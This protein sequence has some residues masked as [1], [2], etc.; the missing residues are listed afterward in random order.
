MHATQILILKTIIMKN[1]LLLAFFFFSSLWF[2]YGQTTIA[3]QNFDGETSWNFASNPSP[4]NISSDVWNS[5]SSIGSINSGNSENFWGMRDLDNPNGG[6]NFDH[7]LTFNA[8]DVSNYNDVV[9]SFD[10]YTVGYESSDVIGYEIWEDNIKTVEVYNLNKSTSAWVNVTYNVTNSANSV[11]LVLK[12]YQ[13]GGSD[14]AGFDNVIINGEISGPSIT[15]APL[16]LTEFTYLE[17]NGPST[18][19]PFTI[20]GTNLTD[21]I[22]V[23][24]PSG[25]EI[26]TT[27]SGGVYQTTPLTLTQISGNV[28]STTILVRLESGLLNINSPFSGNMSCVSNLD[29]L[30]ENMALDGTVTLSCIAPINQPANLTLNNNTTSTIEGDFIGVTADA[31]LV[32]TSTSATLG[33]T[34]MDNNTYNTGDS[35]GSGTVIQSSASNNFV[36]SGLAA[37]TTNYFFVFSYN[38]TSCSGGPAYNTMSPLENNATTMSGPCLDEEFLDFS[39]WT[40]NGTTEDTISS[41]YGI[42]AP[43]RAFGPG[44]DMI[45][46]TVNNPNTLE[47]YQDASS[48]GNGE[49]G[50]VDYRIGAGAWVEFHTFSA[51]T[52]GQTE[53]IDL[54]NLA[55][56]DL[57]QQSNVSFRFNSTFFT[58]YLDDVQVR[59]GASTPSPEIQLV[60][61]SIAT[62]DCGFTLDFGTQ[63]V[64][65]N[66]NRTFDIKNVGTLDLDISSIDIT[67][68]FTIIS[69]INATTGF[70]IAAG[71]TQTVAI[72]FS[73]SVNGP[74]TGMLTINSNDVD[75]NACTILLTGNGMS[76]CVAPLTQAELLVLGNST[77]NTI[78][79]TFTATTADE[80]L[81]IVSTASTLSENPV[82]ATVY[83]T[84]DSIGNGTVVQASDLTTFTATGLS[85]NTEYYVFVF[86]YNA[87]NCTEGPIYNTTDPLF[88]NETTIEGPCVNESFTNQNAPTAAYGN[89]SFTGDDGMTWTYVQARN[90]QG[91]QINGEGLMLRRQTSDSKVTSQTIPNGIGSFTCNL[92]KAFTGAG[93]RQVELFVN[94]N[95]QGTSLAWDNT[96]VQTFTVNDINIAGD[97]VI[98]IRNISGRQVV[99]DNLSWTCFDEATTSLAEIQ[100]VNDDEGIDEA[101]GFSLDFGSIDTTTSTDFSILINNTG[102]EDLV[103]SAADIIGDADF[104]V[105]APANANLGFTITPGNG[106]LLQV[107]FA[108]STTEPRAATLTIHS[109]D[110]DESACTVLLTGEGISSAAKA[111]QNNNTKPSEEANA[112]DFYMYPNPANN[113]LNIRIDNTDKARLTMHTT[114]GLLVLDTVLSQSNTALNLSEIKAGTYIVTLSN[115]KNRLNKLL[116]VKR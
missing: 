51:T 93:D 55:G 88:T 75:E 31:Y 106:Q 104:T 29:A 107:Q 50:T 16:G 33:A 57:S 64:M 63:D 36:A 40:N 54:T 20:E 115:S 62:Q 48:G 60:D 12:A 24:P 96:D 90:D 66:T 65:S 111:M 2:S 10:Y 15:V 19:Q 21:N 82:D 26:A 87:T 32:I 9:I 46:P 25:W 91:Y 78:E 73:P 34:P 43:C 95:S 101:C 4:Y 38:N 72:E 1:Q 98:E 85:Q 84:Y 44:D 18:D 94:G 70:T 97:V 52:S 99:I 37:S 103:V 8:V 67:G 23:T 56:V 45:S 49:I 68:D 92:V 89:G 61:S 11:Y 13:N 47:F 22:V 35:I 80:Y 79:G 58:W 116:V 110:D 42:A 100:L 86:A 112:F 30:T 14:Y 6:G 41:H 17:G 105:I 83:N 39:D 114:T 77:S 53:S 109:N 59:C 27:T 108:P 74:L 71:N 69:P 7:T 81:V 3:E 5:V 28:A 102:T 76:P 113:E